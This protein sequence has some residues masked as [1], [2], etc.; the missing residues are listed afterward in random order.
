M[1]KNILLPLPY[2]SYFGD[3]VYPPGGKL[4][5]RRQT[6]FQLVILHTGQMT[7]WVDEER[8]VVAS[9]RVCILYP[10]HIERFAFASDRNTWHSYVHASF[11]Q[12]HFTMEKR[13]QALPRHIPL[14]SRMTELIFIALSLRD[15]ALPTVVP[16]LHTI[17]L[18]MIWL[19]VGEGELARLGNTGHDLHT[20]VTMAC[21]YIHAN[22]DES[23][24]IKQIADA[25][26]CS[27]SH[28]TRLFKATQGQSVMNYVWSYRVRRGIELLKYT[29]LTIGDIA[30][31]CGF[32]NQHHFSKRVRTATDATPSEIRS[33]ATHL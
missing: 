21:E 5:A 17:A 27:P 7:V 8:I 26:L 2:D 22:F 20:S 18:Q 6:N 28:L 29:G 32:Q 31:R 9:P 30:H 14:S 25:A 10:E 23:L 13:L 16:L 11:D 3:V 4:P 19:Y 15:S 33:R 24:T 12:L 1:S